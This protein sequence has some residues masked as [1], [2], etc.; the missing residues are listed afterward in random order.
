M[1]Y[2]FDKQVEPGELIEVADGVLWL[3]MPLPFEL[4][5]INLYLIRGEGGW[6]VIDTGIGTSTTKSL[7]MRIFEQLDAPIVGVIVTHLHPDH[8]GLAGWIAD[9]YNVPF[10]MTQTEYFTARAFAAGRNGATNTRDVLYYQRAGL[11]DPMIAKLT[12]GEGNGYSSVVSPLPI[13]YTR[14]KHGMTLFLGDNEWV[15][16]IGR[17]HSPE[18][19]CLYNA[20][21]NIL[22]SGDHILPIIT[23]NIGAYSTEPDANTLAD[24]LNTL[25]QFKSLPRNTTVLPAHKLPFIG[26]HERVDS[27]IAHHHEHL[28]ALLKACKEPKAVVDLLPVMFR[29]KLSSRNMVFAVAECL[30]HLNYLVSEGD[31]SRALNDE[32]VYTFKVCAASKLAS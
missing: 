27:L 15:V 22:I 8:V 17:G 14:L 29:R 23:P 20:K 28:Q 25:P 6:V 26:L 24:Y 18:H 19:A 32:G 9:T 30:S 7:W 2:L 10:Y 31:I 1:E 12:S 13:S 16:M 4:D 5:H 21:K 11:D 3:T